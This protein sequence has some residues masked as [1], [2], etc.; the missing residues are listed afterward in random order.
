M[1]LIEEALRKTR[2]QEAAK[3]VRSAPH[4]PAVARSRA[5]AE[6]EVPSRTFRRAVV[7]ATQLEKNRIL[8]GVT[9]VAVLRAYKIL[10]TRVLQRMHAENWRSVG[11]TGTMAGEGKTVT[12]INLAIALAQETNTRVFL[13]DLD[14]Q[15]PRLA[16]Y[17]GM[18]VEKGLSD[19]LLNQASFDDVVYDLGIN[20]L[21]VIP[22]AHSIEQSSEAL[23]SPRMM[24]MLQSLLAEQPQRLVVFDMPP[25][26]V[27]DDVLAFAPRADSFL[28]VAAQGYT[29]RRALEN[30][31]EILSGMNLV[32]VVLN[33][34]SERNDSPYY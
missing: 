21:S 4:A 14:L 12:S 23:S 27:S 16:S 18:D 20:R 32:G 33:R 10:R 5:P 26:L 30:A 25:L 11:V 34:S 15:R 1:S 13:V 22:N 31:R 24:E 8:P 17:L 6:P 2:Q 28:L 19:Y 7:D 29:Q 3:K 9:D